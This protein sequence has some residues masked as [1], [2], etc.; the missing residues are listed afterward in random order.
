MS[1]QV[2]GPRHEPALVPGE[3]RGYRQFQLRADGLY[4][5]VRGGSGPWD[6]HLERAMCAA[7]AE[8][9]APAVDCRCGL[10]A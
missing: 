6:G 10:Y 7:G 4:P 1:L 9:P 3:L 8:H 2:S 5:L